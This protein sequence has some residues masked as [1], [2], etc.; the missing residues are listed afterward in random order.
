[1]KEDIDYHIYEDDIQQGKIGEEL[2]MKYLNKNSIQFQDVRDTP[3]FM[4]IDVDF[5][6]KKDWYDVKMNYKNNGVIILET[7]INSDLR[8]GNLIIGWLYNSQADY[9]IFISFK[10]MIKLKNNMKFHNWLNKHID[11]YPET[12]NR[13]TENNRKQ[14]TRVG[15]YI[16]VPLDDIPSKFYKKIKLK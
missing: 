5:V 2:F 12:T 13:R 8:Y 7:K 1:M 14:I 9:F 4:K 10:W 3:D 6:I 15:A 16:K 11:E